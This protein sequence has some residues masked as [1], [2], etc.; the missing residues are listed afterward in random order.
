MMKPSPTNYS[1]VTL[2][3][4]MATHTTF[5]FCEQECTQRK[6]AAKPSSF[7]VHRV[8]KETKE[9]GQ[10]STTIISFSWS[11]TQ[12]SRMLVGIQGD[13]LGYIGPCTN[14][15]TRKVMMKDIS[16]RDYGSE[17]N[18]SDGR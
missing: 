9:S 11:R 15:Y 13:L 1:I 14:R 8:Q 6:Y 5:I 17:S 18:K 10:E 16:G 2:P 7:T 12:L 3:I 4:C